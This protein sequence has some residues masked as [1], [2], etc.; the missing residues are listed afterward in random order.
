[1]VN[2]GDGVPS[3]VRAAGRRVAVLTAWIN[4]QFGPKR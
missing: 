4:E 3:D 1:V 2:N